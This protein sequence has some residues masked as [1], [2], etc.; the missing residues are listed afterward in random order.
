MK[1]TLVPWLFMQLRWGFGDGVGAGQGS[2]SGGGG[3]TS[4]NRIVHYICHCVLMD[5][6]GD[7]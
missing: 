7:R 5:D 2:G 4:G 6:S 3:A 1:N